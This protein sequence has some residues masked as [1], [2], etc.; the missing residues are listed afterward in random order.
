MG[1]ILSKLL[2]L[3]LYPLGLALLLQLTALVAHRRRWSPWL[4]AAA[5]ALLWIPATPLVS[6]QLVWGL[7]ESCAAL[8]RAR[9]PQ[10]DAIVVR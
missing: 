9:I 7:E 2:P 10:A 1:F 5:I 8:T 6:R 4:S 3:G